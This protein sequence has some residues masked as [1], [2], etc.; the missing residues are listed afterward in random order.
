MEAASF[1]TE[2]YE[3][4]RVEMFREGLVHYDRATLESVYESVKAESWNVD[5]LAH[6]LDLPRPMYGRYG[7]LR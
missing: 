2:D 4:R 1:P 5:Q 7:R 6:F 3:K